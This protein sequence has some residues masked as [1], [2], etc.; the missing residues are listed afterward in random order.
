MSRQLRRDTDANLTRI[1][2]HADPELPQDVATKNYVDSNSRQV[3][4]TAV[5]GATLSGH[6]I[7]TRRSNGK[8]TYASN[9]DLTD[10]NAPMW[11]TIASAVLDAPVPV[12]L[13]GDVEEPS[14]SW[15]PG[16]AIYLTAAGALTQVVPI[17]PAAFLV[18]VGY[19]TGTTSIVFD[20]GLSIELI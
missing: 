17:A 2:N 3:L 6:R 20:R 4:D 11:L 7:V 5:A 18:Q 10:V 14:W 19:A 12:L 9:A 1:R 13:F 15:T 8:V 16:A